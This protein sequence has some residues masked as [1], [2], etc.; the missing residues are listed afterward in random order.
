MGGDRRRRHALR[1]RS[2]A[3]QVGMALGFLT[4]YPVNAWLIRR[5]I[6]EAM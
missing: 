2:H 6:K 5:G 3:M 4:A 1:G